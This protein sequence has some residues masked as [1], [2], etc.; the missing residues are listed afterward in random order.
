M[1]AVTAEQLRELK[2]QVQ[3][4]RRLAG[5]PQAPA[6]APT[7]WVVR[8][9]SQP[10]CTAH[11]TASQGYY[12]NQQSSS[13]SSQ[14]P[15]LQSPRSLLADEAEKQLNAALHTCTSERLQKLMPLQ[16]RVREKLVSVMHSVQHLPDEAYTASVHLWQQQY[17]REPPRLKCGERDGERNTSGFIHC[18]S[19]SVPLRASDIARCWRELEREWRTATDSRRT[20]L[21]A[22]SRQH[23]K[24]QRDHAK[25]SDSV[26]RKREEAIRRND[27]HTYYRLLNANSDSVAHDGQSERKYKELESFLQ[28]SEAYMRMLSN[29][30][31]SVKAQQGATVKRKRWQDDGSKQKRN[32]RKK[33]RKKSH[34][35]SKEDDARA[36]HDTGTQANGSQAGDDTKGN[37]D[38]SDTKQVKTEDASDRDNKSDGEDPD[39]E[40][41][42]DEEDEDE[43]G[44]VYYNAAH[45][46]AES[47]TRQPSM[48]ERGHLR[49]YQMQGLQWLV[50]LY[51]NGLNGILADE[52]GLGKT[53]QTLALLAYLWECKANFG[54]HLI[55]VPNSVLLS[56]KHEVHTWLPSVH[57][58][59]YHGDKNE[60]KELHRT[61]L[62][63]NNF[64]VLVTTYEYVISDNA[65]LCRV[66]WKYIIIDEAQRLKNANAKLNAN[67]LR[68]NCQNRLLLTGTPLQNELRELWSLLHL[69]LPRVFDSAR[70]FEEWFGTQQQQNAQDD[71]VER[72]RKKIVIYRLHQILEPFMLRRLVSDVEGKLP[73]KQSF[74]VKCPLSGLQ[75]VVYD[76]ISRTGTRRNPPGSKTRLSPVTNKVQELKKVC[77]HPRLSSPPELGGPAHLGNEITRACGKLWVLDIMLPKLFKA[78]HKVLLF[79]SM[80]KLL[81]V[82]ELYLQWRYVDGKPLKY[83]RLDGNTSFSDRE[84][85]VDAFNAPDSDD[86]IFL[87]SIRAAGRGLNLQ[88][89][90]TVVVYDPDPNPKNEEQAIARAHRI[91]QK[92]EV[93]VYHLESVVEDKRDD[94]AEGNAEL[95]PFA[96]NKLSVYSLGNTKREYRK[97]VETLLRENIQQMK[98]EM[99]DEV[100]DAGRFDQRTSN[101]AR[102]QQLEQ[103]LNER[104]KFKDTSEQ[105]VPDLQEINKLLA[106]SEKELELFRQMDAAEEAVDTF[107]SRDGTG[108]GDYW[109]P[110]PMLAGDDIPSWMADD[111]ISEDDVAAAKGWRSKE[112]SAEQLSRSARTARPQMGQLQEH[113]DDDV[114]EQENQSTQNHQ[115]DENMDDAEAD[116]EARVDQAASVQL[117]M[118]QPQSTICEEIP[119]ETLADEDDEDNPLSNTVDNPAPQFGPEL[120]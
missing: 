97:S 49:P 115:L 41:D 32:K 40:A 119:E 71:W 100:I 107:M 38:A 106:R 48:L 61:V 29:K 51:N 1:S 101:K 114:G 58:V 82:M 20:R 118:Q 47:V 96:R 39:E 78:G 30:I 11:V 69:L 117:A 93:R 9:P 46:V 14:L 104:A 98:V 24:L 72:E 54:P 83:R 21:H 15:F 74:S 91:G 12:N 112:V 2:A 27:M 33:K 103:L 28:K 84:K 31:A 70:S 52:M 102:E 63:Q 85:A 64:N 67:V 113:D 66:N 75:N 92:R 34:H 62:E 18:G 81:D 89:A 7:E 65:R 79:S 3:L 25:K 23:D 22:V 13:E 108:K 80:T 105:R 90:D 37:G 36:K 76:W 5:V 86:F 95:E 59:F 110:M 26:E 45:T 109:L 116:D 42:E 99:A 55:I 94:D 6:S 50:S 43:E 60:R 19:P 10:L 17:T 8:R 44:N 16:K 87:L 68:L 111:S 56:W 57:V 120:L 73:P 77:N 35:V 4:Y 53:L 88:T